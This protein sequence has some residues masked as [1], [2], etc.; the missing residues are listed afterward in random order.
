MKQWWKRNINVS[1]GEHTREG[2]EDVTGCI[3]L[4][5][6]KCVEGD[7]INLDY[8]FFRDIY[9]QAKMFEQEMRKL[10]KSHDDTNWA[11]YATLH[12]FYPYNVT[13]FFQALQLHKGLPF[14]P[15][16]SGLVKKLSRTR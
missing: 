5:L 13:N 16:C 2:V 3:P 7:K 15:V 4:L 1:L 11:V 8:A 14:P 6:D 9:T 12:W 10:K